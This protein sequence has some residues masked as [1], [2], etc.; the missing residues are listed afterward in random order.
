[1]GLQGTFKAAAQTIFE[2]FGDVPVSS[3]YSS[4]D[5]SI[6]YNPSGSGTI[7]DTVTNETVDIIFAYYEVAQIDGT[8]VR[9]SDQKA[10]IP[11]ENL[12]AVPGQ[13]DYITTSSKRWNVVAVE[14]DPAEALWILQIRKP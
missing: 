8:K 10:M 4:V 14:T 1:M 5:D 7:T 2:A 6:A 9:A 11:V 3:T 13:K 12:T